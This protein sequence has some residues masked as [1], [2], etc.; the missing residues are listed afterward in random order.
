M[1]IAVNGVIILDTERVHPF[2]WRF[3][4]LFLRLFVAFLFVQCSLL[5]SPRTFPVRRPAN[6]VGGNFVVPLGR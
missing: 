4:G 6:R 3:F 1:R 5:S 2:T